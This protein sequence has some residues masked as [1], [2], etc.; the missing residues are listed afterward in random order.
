[1]Q[2]DQIRRQLEHY[3]R[4]RA[5]LERQ[6]ADHRTAVS[7]AR[8]R[9]K[10]F[11]LRRKDL[12]GRIAAE[13]EQLRKY[14]NQQLSVKKNEEYRAFEQEIA[15][16]QERIEALENEDLDVLMKIDEATDTLRAAESAANEDIA[17]L[18]GHIERLRANEAEAREQLG[19]AERRAAA[20]AEM[21]EPGVLQSYRYVRGRVRKPPYV[22]PLIDKQCQ[23]CFLRVSTEVESEARRREGLARCDSCG[24]LVYL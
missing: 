7:A 18:E 12:E 11:E 16:C 14:R 10:E 22:V 24:R 23:G 3:P 21:L 17:V 6:I 4:D 1:M 20:A 19:E 15:T 8:E 5:D 2:C 9:L 13:E